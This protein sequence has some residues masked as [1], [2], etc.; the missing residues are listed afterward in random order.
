MLLSHLICR[1]TKNFWVVFFFFLFL[2]LLLDSTLFH[3]KFLS[4]RSSQPLW[5]F[6]SW[7]SPPRSLSLALSFHFSLT[8]FSLPTPGVIQGCGVGSKTPLKCLLHWDYFKKP[9]H[10][11]HE[12]ALETKLKHDLPKCESRIIYSLESFVVPLACCLPLL[13][14]S[15]HVSF[16]CLSVTSQLACFYTCPWSV[17]LKAKR[18][19]I[20][21]LPVESSAFPMYNRGPQTPH[22]HTKLANDLVWNDT[23]SQCFTGYNNYTQQK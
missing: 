10:H 4:L 9:F 7:V 22:L 2:L 21:L 16:Y 6:C 3:F 14:L 11:V 19:E 23:L 15:H 5:L 8:L 17:S 12:A 13:F 1:S 20:E 18:K